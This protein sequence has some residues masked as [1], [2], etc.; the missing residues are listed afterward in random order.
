MRFVEWLN[1]N[2]GAVQALATVVLVVITASYARRTKQIAEATSEQA[3]LLRKASIPEVSIRLSM[4]VRVPQGGR[5]F[6][7]S[8][9]NAGQLP[10]TVQ[11]PY[12]KLPDGRSIV[13]PPG[14]ASPTT[15]FPVALDRGA[16]C[17]VHV[18]ASQ[19]GDGLLMVGIGAPAVICAAVDD[20]T[21]RT[22]ESNTLSVDPNELTR[23]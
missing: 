5:V 3:A 12:I 22:Y 6:I 7:L 14:S 23:G 2:A 8:A 10:V 21:G 1:T 15:R 20:L 17:E 11:Q 13:F 9:S 18:S 16:G 19:V 4:G